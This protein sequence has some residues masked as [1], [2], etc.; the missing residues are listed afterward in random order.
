M[1]KAA[2]VVLALMMAAGAAYLL[3]RR[4][5]PAPAREAFRGL[6]PDFL[7]AWQA[8]LS[9]LRSSVLWQRVPLPRRHR[10]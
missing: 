1:K 10:N 4:P 9:A 8:D 7:L 6:P 3:R 2:L 5:A